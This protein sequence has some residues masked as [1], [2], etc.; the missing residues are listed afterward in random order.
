METQTSQSLW[1]RVLHFARK[2]HGTVSRQQLLGLGYSGGAIK[3]LV[4]SGRL[5]PT[6]WRGV[7]V[8]GRP[9]LTEFGRMRAALLTCGND[10]ILV[11]ETAGALWRIWKPRDRSI[12]LSLP[13]V[14]Q[15]RPRTGIV[16][17]RRILR[18][19]DVTRQR[20]IPVTTPLRTV[21]DLAAL[22]DRRRAERLI[23]EAD[24]SGLVRADTLRAE[25]DAAKGQPGVPLLRDI[26]D[27]D[28]FVLTDSELERLFLP[29]TY[30]A[31]LPKPQSQKR[32]GPH[33]VDFFWPELNLVVE[34]DSLRYHRTPLQQRADTE[35]DHAHLLAGRRRLRFTYDQIAHD[36]DYV[37]ATLTA[38]S[39][40]SA[41]SSSPSA[42]CA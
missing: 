23:N 8:V 41:P 7:Y 20:G 33:R 12:H 3:R 21:I 18:R 27:R 16:V 11:G 29:L 26:L 15:R 40:R 2:Q 13:A 24:A 5:F 36:P 39:L 22:C 30:R 9:E 31:G 37:V 10:A 38:L 6:D 4:A 25:A 19:K 35:R 28:A 1:E 17:H 32:F 42:T 14:Q 34:V